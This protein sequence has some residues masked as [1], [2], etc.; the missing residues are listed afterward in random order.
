MNNHPLDNHRP[1]SVDSAEESQPI[2]ALP[3]GYHHPITAHSCRDGC[4][5]DLPVELLLKLPT[6]RESKHLIFGSSRTPTAF[7]LKLHFV[8]TNPK[9]F[10]QPLGL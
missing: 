7:F 10:L 6:D 3:R 4:T 9:D 1:I 8:N 5:C 2:P